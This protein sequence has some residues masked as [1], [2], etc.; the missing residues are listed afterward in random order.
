MATVADGNLFETF[1]DTFTFPVKFIHTGF[2]RPVILNMT[3]GEFGICEFGTGKI[4]R[5]VKRGKDVNGKYFV[6]YDVVFIGGILIRTWI[7]E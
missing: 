2:P 3:E 4:H 1:R 7:G 5:I 6:V